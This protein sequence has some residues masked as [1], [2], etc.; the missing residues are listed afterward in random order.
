MKKPP[1]STRLRIAIVSSMD[2]TDRRPWSGLPFFMAKALQEY[3]GD[4]I[5]LGPVKSHYLNMGKLLDWTGRALIGRSVD[6]QHNLTLARRYAEHFGNQLRQSPCDIIFAPAASTE[7]A[8][9]ETSI[10]IVYATDATFRLLNGYYPFYQRLTSWSARSADSIEGLALKNASAVVYPTPWP[11][12]S[13]MRDYGVD[14]STVHVVPYGSN[15]DSAPS[16]EVIHSKQ[17]SEQCRLLFIAVDWERKGG[18][19]SFETLLELEKL[20]IKSELTVVGCVPP[21]QFRHPHLRIIPFLNKN[22]EEERQIFHNTLLTS[23]FLLLPTR[24]EAF[25][26]VYCEASAYGLPSISTNT[27]GV[28]GVVTDGKNGYLLPPQACGVEYAR[29]IAPLFVDKKRL[30]RL[31]KSS[32]AIYDKKLNWDAWGTEMNKIMTRLT[33]GTGR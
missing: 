2:P 30:S 24:A 21:R 29:L 15:I 9:L 23:D 31:V 17:F 32:R 6:Y 16:I 22:L 4:V 20:G 12:Q 19:I 18:A 7:I 28:S 13:A 8:F 3:C 14:E 27:G 33:I 11:V 25:G 10:P 5:I 1:R 26:I